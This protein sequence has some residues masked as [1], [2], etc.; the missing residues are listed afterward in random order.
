[1]FEVRRPYDEI[2]TG[3]NDGAAQSASDELET[4]YAAKLFALT[5]WLRKH[6]A[7]I[8]IVGS[9]PDQ[10]HRRYAAVAFTVI[11][12][13]LFVWIVIGSLRLSATADG[14]EIHL[15]LTPFPHVDV[16]PLPRVPEPTL[17]VIEMPEIAIQTEAPMSAPAAA[18]ASAVLAP[19]P[20]PTHPNPLPA[21]AD[22]GAGNVSPIVM[23]L[24]I[25]VL[26]DGSANDAEVVKSSGQHD[27]DL[28]AI[29]FVKSKR[30]F[31]PALLGGTAIQY[32]TTVSLRTG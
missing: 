31:L 29:A 12:N 19:R 18:S 22:M 5:D 16:V 13:S 3:A 24:K 8:P 23:V 9:Q 2:E 6:A 14:D 27:S 28:A 30:R 26:P 4:R 32:W 21:S 7:W 1:M 25:M 10:Q 17:P 15:I 20:D 11:L